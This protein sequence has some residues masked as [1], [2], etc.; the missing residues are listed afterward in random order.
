MCPY[1]GE[2]LSSVTWIETVETTYAARPSKKWYDFYYS[3]LE[4]K[5]TEGGFYCPKCS[6]K[7]G[8]DEIDVHSHRVK[9]PEYENP[10]EMTRV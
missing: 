9:Q 4:D 1:C 8:D 2:I 6:Q 10:R 5:T 3:K 7:I